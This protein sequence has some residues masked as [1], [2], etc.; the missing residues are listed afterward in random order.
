MLERRHSQRARTLRA[1]KIVF[2]NKNSV[3]DCMVRNHPELKDSQIMRLVGTTKSTIQAIRERTHWN[4][5]NIKPR[6]PV[7]L[8]LCT[9]AEL[10]AAVARA[11]RGKKPAEAPAAAPTEA[12]SPAEEDT[13]AG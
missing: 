6:H 13:A 9:L 1:G 8:G 4:A 10:D 5:P 7:S 11:N 12:A 2:N 3:I